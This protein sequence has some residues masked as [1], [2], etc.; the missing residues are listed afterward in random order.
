MGPEGGGVGGGGSGEGERD[1]TTIC[2]FDVD[3][4]LSPSRKV[5]S[6][7]MKACLDRLRTKCVVGIVSGS[8]LKKIQE[9]LG[10]DMVQKYDYAFTE[11]G[12]VAHH[13]GSLLDS[14]SILDELGEEKTQD[15]INF[16]L[17]YM[18]QLRLPAKRGTFVEFRTGL[19][20]LCPVGR[21]CTQAERDAFA[22]FDAEHSIRP[23]MVAALNKRFPDDKLNFAIGGQISIDV[24]PQ[25]WDKRYCLR[26]L[27]GNFRRIL[28]FGDRTEP[29]G[30]DHEIYSDSRTEGVAVTGPE[31][32]MRQLNKL[33]DV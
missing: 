2:L 28:F 16:S 18:S 3:G 21:S 11:N 19:I 24:F 20:N 23:K 1:L 26:F 22:A 4:T 8:D 10:D 12:L 33:F 32:T 30:N 6:D 13:N 27:E 7:E 14:K 31:D 5:A 9:Q 17:S 25:G 15:L 29:G